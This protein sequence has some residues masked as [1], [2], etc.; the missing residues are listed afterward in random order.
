MW[1]LEKQVSFRGSLENQRGR[2]MMNININLNKRKGFLISPFIHSAFF[3]YFG[4]TIYDGIWVGPGSEIPNDGGIRQAVID[5]CKEAGIAAMRWPGGCCADFYHWKYGIGKNRKPR[6]HPVPNPGSPLIYH[7]FGTDE[8]L[9][10]CCL[11][12]AEPIIVANA[13][14]GTAEEF[15]DWYEYV[16][17]LAETY[18][19]SMRAENGHPEPYNV[20]YWGIGN[21]D[22]NIWQTCY[23]DPV[24]YAR[25]YLKFQAALRQDRFE[26]LSFI[27]LGLSHR[28]NLPGG[29]VGKYLDY[30]T[31]D[32]KDRGPDFLSIHNYLGGRME[33]S[34]KNAGP[35]VDFTDEQYYYLLDSLKHYQID[36]DLH[37]GFILEHTNPAFPTKIC[38]DEWGIWHPEATFE[39][40]QNQRQ[41][42]RDAIF[43]AKALHIFYR[44]CDIVEFAMETQLCNLLQSLFETRGEK[45]YK[46]PTFYAMKLLK[47]HKGQ[48]MADVLPAEEDKDVDISASFNAD[49][50]VISVVNQNLHE[51]KSIKIILPNMICTDARIVTC[52]D[53]RMVNS[54]DSPFNIVD[55]PYQGLTNNEFSLPPFS[56]VRVVFGRS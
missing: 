17:G 51:K 4:T 15:M 19:G 41:T 30:V 46:T 1:S 33:N 39:N 27:G 12:S 43:A 20:K 8:F 40:D 44:N 10:F 6:Y 32:R 21:T 37:R 56:I 35:A 5:G 47:E 53:V 3:E 54:F 16:N 38:F 29:W 45:F 11:C 9:R 42:M 2:M 26:K 25:T 22:E 52:K 55:M 31:R 24:N 13:A 50:L 7:E 48:Y 28:H 23:N 14:L 18:Y 36:I 34:A 49:R